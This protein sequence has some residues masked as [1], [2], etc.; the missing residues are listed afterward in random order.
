MSK[1]QSTSEKQLYRDR[2]LKARRWFK[3]MMID[4]FPR[5]IKISEVNSNNIAFPHSGFRIGLRVS[6]PLYMFYLKKE[7][8][9]I[10]SFEVKDG[11]VWFLLIY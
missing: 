10:H 5:D 7:M 11:W 8:N 1:Q 3:E 9:K 6:R 2:A 4:H